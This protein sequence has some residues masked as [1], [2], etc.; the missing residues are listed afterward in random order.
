[1][2]DYVVSNAH[3]SS[4]VAG[5]PSAFP[6]HDRFEDDYYLEENEAAGID[7]RAIWSALYRNRYLIAAV[8]AAALLIGLAVTFL[9][10]RIYEAHATVQIEQ[11]VTRILGTEDTEAAASMQDADRFLET[12]LDVIR[13]RYLAERVAEDLGLFRDDQFLSLMNVNVPEKPSGTLNLEQTKRESVLDALLENRSVSLPRNSRIARIG[14]ASPDPVLAAKVANS[15]AK[16]YI[17]TNLQRKFDASGYARE[18][19]SN[20]LADSKQRLEDSEREMLA[21][22]RAAGLIDTSG[23]M[24]NDEQVGASRSLTTSSLVQLNNAHAE[25]VAQRIEAQQ[26]WQ[27]A[28]GTATLALPEVLENPAIQELIQQR[29]ELQALYQQERQRRREDFPAV[30]QAAARI[31]ELNRQIASLASNIKSGIRQQYQI[32]REQELALERNIA[33]LKG[34]TL[35]E[36]DRS[37]RYNILK[38]QTD[39]NREMYEALLQRY[40]EV[41]A[42]AGVTANNL[43]ILDDADRPTSPVSPKPV[44]NMALAGMAGLALALLLVL[45]RERFDDVIRSPED[46][47]PK[48]GIA[49]LGTIPVL[50]GDKQPRDAL[51]E[52]RSPLSEAYQALRTSLELSAPAGLPRTIM[53]T[54]SQQGEGKSTSAY[55]VARDFSRTGKR[56]LLIDADLRKPSLH[57]TLSQPNETGL[58]NLLAGQRTVTDVVQTTAEPNL[59][60]IAAGPLPPNPAELLAAGS[61][62]E[63]LAKL[64]DIYDLVVFDAP[65]VM[66]L[67][68]APLLASHMGG[69]VFVIEANRAHRGQAKIA[70]RRLLSTQAKIL[71]AVLTKFDVKAIGYGQDYGYGYR[72]GE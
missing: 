36:Q 22:A 10:P 54:S 3:V 59:N 23:G 19:L 68:D 38:R 53:F 43:S 41:S 4:A 65:P 15:F 5:R 17:T 7:L 11:D 21:Y 14:F 61:I 52:P 60:F 18:F 2:N 8:V 50:K 63:L 57:S 47:T 12:Q 9:M 70:L 71:G 24:T 30:Q 72:Y 42:E 6:G 26:K 35:S 45:A 29:A 51:A 13:S 64:T 32:T 16:N 33:R 20:Q 25:A 67:A 34:E 56:V 44:L 27:S 55:A 40:R 28:R 48:L 62:E 49:P 37:V 69:T 31:A 66:G 46:I 58:S 39:T 1:M